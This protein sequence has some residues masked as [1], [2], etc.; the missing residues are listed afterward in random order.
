MALHDIVALTYYLEHFDANIISPESLLVQVT[1]YIGGRWNIQ[2]SSVK[3]KLAH[4][5][6]IA[7]DARARIF[8]ENFVE[9]YLEGYDQ[10]SFFD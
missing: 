1:R 4:R 3:K 2:V 5:I 8:R 7:P 9:P 6:C 10:T